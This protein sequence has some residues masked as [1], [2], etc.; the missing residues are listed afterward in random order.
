MKFRY[1]SRFEK[2]LVIFLSITF[3]LSLFFIAEHFLTSVSE[4]NPGKGGVYSEGMVGKTQFI[5]PVF[6]D[7]NPIDTD[8]SSLVFSGLMKY[9]PTTAGIIDDIATHTLD[10]SKKVYTFTLKEKTF[11]HDEQKVTADDIMFTFQ[12][13]IQNPDFKNSLLRENF[14]GVTLKKINDTTV[15][16]TLEKPYKFFLSNLTIGL[17]PKHILGGIPLENLHLSEFNYINPVG[18][19]PYKFSNF[20]EGNRVSRVILKKN[21]L[22]YNNPANIEEIILYLFPSFEQLQASINVLDGV[23]NISKTYA[24]AFTNLSPFKLHSF[25]KPQYVA[26]F[27]NTQSD[28]LKD[29]KTRLGLA[30]GLDK[31]QILEEMKEEQKIDTPFLEL[32]ESNW[33]FQF[34]TLKAQGALNDA[35][36]KLPWKQEVVEKKKEVSPESPSAKF[37]SAPNNGSNW[38]TSSSEFFIEGKVPQS[39]K[40]VLINGYQLRLFE[41]EKSTFTYKASTQLG[42]MKEAE[43][44][45]KL[46]VIDENDKKIF[47]DT[48]QIYYS[49]DTEEVNAKQK[50]YNEKEELKI[51]TSDEKKEEAKEINETDTSTSEEVFRINENGETLSLRVISSK[52]PKEYAVAAEEL[53]S[54]WKEIGIDAHIELLETVELQERVKNRDYDVLIF[55]QSLGYNLDAYPYWHSSQADNGFNFSQLK[56]FAVDTLLEEIRS[57]HDEEKRQKKL[58]EVETV[59]IEEMPAIFL[60][61]P[62]RNFT[63]STRVKGAEIENIRDFK[64]RFSHIEKWYVNEEKKLKE[65]VGVLDFFK[66]LLSEIR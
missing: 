1:L 60:Y 11:W 14:K 45:Y 43:N 4:L 6:A 8:I 50:E 5:N 35:G 39:T 18:T 40:A 13:V 49:K 3:F 54:F 34:D 20:I 48:L 22:Y 61:S 57:T 27:F 64:D 17:L 19:G 9:D 31:P 12:E 66:W 41:T 42:T 65:D 30:L 2:I 36:W 25:T 51:S 24:P 28:I 29:K 21:N 58:K 46:E 38:A 56:N 33:L 55:G 7:L 52:E 26:A 23:Q 63:L 47:L 16:F 59:L 15:T 44:N 62:Q 32:G 53:K 37:F 10:I